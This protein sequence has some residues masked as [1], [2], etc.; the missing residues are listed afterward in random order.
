MPKRYTVTN[1][2]IILLMRVIDA[3]IIWCTCRNKM[4]NHTEFQNKTMQNETIENQN[5]VV[6]NST[7]M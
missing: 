1:S 5:I 7:L 2:L 6:H 3:K 4:N